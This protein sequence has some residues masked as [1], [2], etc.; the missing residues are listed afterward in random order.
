MFFEL[1]ADFEK[2]F[3]DLDHRCERRRALRLQTQKNAGCFQYRSFSLAIRAEK[4]I[5]SRTDID[6]QAFEATEI[7]QPQTR[8]HLGKL[9]DDFRVLTCLSGNPAAPI[10]KRDA[11]A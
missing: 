7:A 4:Q 1:A 8:Q 5:E 6:R 11:R 10:A 2:C 9:S 3:T